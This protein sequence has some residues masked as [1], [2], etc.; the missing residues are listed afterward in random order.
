MQIYLILIDK[1]IFSTDIIPA[2]FSSLRYRSFF[3]YNIY[4]DY[5]QANQALATY[6][7]D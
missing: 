7:E 1:I 3:F 4:Q 2:H 5:I 6:V